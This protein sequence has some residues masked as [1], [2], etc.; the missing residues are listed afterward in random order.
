MRRKDIIED[1]RVCHI[2][3]MQLTPHVKHQS[4]NPSLLCKF[5]QKKKQNTTPHF[6]TITQSYSNPVDKSFIKIDFNSKTVH[7]D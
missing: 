6:L 2:I 7:K 3:V 1:D 5:Q 4:G